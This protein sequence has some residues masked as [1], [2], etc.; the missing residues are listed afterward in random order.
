MVKRLCEIDMQKIAKP[1]DKVSKKK[2][3]PKV[4]ADVV[5]PVVE[6]PKHPT[7]GGKTLETLKIIKE[8]QKKVPTEAQ[9]ASRQRQKEARELKKKTELE[10]AAS[11]LAE[12]ERKEKEAAALAEAKLYKRK[13][14]AA[15]RKRIKAE[16]AAALQAPID[17]TPAKSESV[18][19]IPEPRKKYKAPQEEVFKPSTVQQP[20][21][22]G[23]WNASSNQR[24]MR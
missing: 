1:V 4:I 8:S 11:I 6:E 13:E 23:V 18:T 16:E 17:Q 2:K 14:K 24:R 5:E 21:R 22:V 7:T 12:Q 19:V 15:E 20:K 9:L 10:L 3:A